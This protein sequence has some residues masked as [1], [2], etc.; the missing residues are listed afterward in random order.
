[1][2]SCRADISKA[3]ERL[4]WEPKVSFEEGVTEMLNHIDY[5]REAPVWDAESIQTATRTWFDMFAKV[6]K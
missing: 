5:W 2:C 3:R 1:M 4:G 6:G